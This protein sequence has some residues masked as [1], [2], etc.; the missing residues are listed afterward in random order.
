MI[1]RNTVLVLGAGASK[2]YG[3]P[4]GSE[5][6]RNILNMRWGDLYGVQFDPGDV[7]PDRFFD[8]FKSSFQEAGDLSI[9]AFLGANP[10]FMEIG[11]LAIAACLLPK[12]RLGELFPIDLPTDHWYGYLAERLPSDPENLIDQNI[13]FVT[14]NYD[15][16]LE[17]YF[18]TRWKNRHG[19]PEDRAWELVRQLRIVHVYGQLGALG[20]VPRQYDGFVP[21]GGGR[22]LSRSISIAAM[23]LKLIDDERHEESL[24]F[25]TART[26]IKEAEV[27]GFLGFA[28]DKT[29]V[30]RLGGTAIN[31]SR[32]M[33][34][35]VWP[36]RF[37]ASALG[38]T[39][40]ERQSR[41][42][43]ISKGGGLQPPEACFFDKESLATL[44]ESQI[45]GY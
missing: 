6:R 10:D 32:F 15:R 3:L 16:S 13:S 36:P 39:E 30:N 34:G 12:E 1:E 17:A 8:R 37:A 28:F 23:G 31:A 33:T 5:L 20:P 42:M 45:L 7:A 24:E 41:Y 40:R 22:N 26:W 4:L 44:R 14:F 18:L 25:L 35:A 11:K 43:A 2:P 9:D 19:L 27:L 29:N 38:S 21:Y